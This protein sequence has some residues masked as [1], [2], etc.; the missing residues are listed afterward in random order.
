[1]LD[2][3][4]RAGI[5]LV[6]PNSP[7]PSFPLREETERPYPPPTIRDDGVSLDSRSS[8]LNKAEAMH[9]A[10]AGSVGPTMPNGRG[11]AYES[12][13][14]PPRLPRG[15]GWPSTRPP[16]H[17]ASHGP[18][19]PLTSGRSS[20]TLDVAYKHGEYDVD[21][22]S[23]AAS[24]GHLVMGGD[25]LLRRMII[26]PFSRPPQSARDF[27]ASTKPRE[28]SGPASPTSSSDN[29]GAKSTA[30]HIVN[31]LIAN[32]PGP[33][34]CTAGYPLLMLE[35][36]PSIAGSPIRLYNTRCSS[37]PYDSALA[38]QTAFRV[39]PSPVETGDELWLA[40]LIVAEDSGEW[41]WRWM[42]VVPPDR[43]VEGA[44]H[45]MYY[46]A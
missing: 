12:A 3:G 24:R 35:V 30:D 46:H 29:A 10:F 32:D 31:P 36:A 6:P 27:V 40:T 38:S 28:G 43:H 42:Y 2:A 23:H 33:F 17:T 26:T 44:L 4:R 22:E 41:N 1:M 13:V 19:M 21:A 9:G 37:G 16:S 15:R 8:L 45:A 39:H 11:D 25:G 20:S 14:R 34:W 7:D 5:M 18:T